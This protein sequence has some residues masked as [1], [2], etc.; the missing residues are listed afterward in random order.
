M[1]DSLYSS[2]D[3]DINMPLNKLS[4]LKISGK[5]GFKTHHIQITLSKYI[6]SDFL[7][8]YL[9]W[10]KSKLSQLGEFLE[11]FYYVI[12]RLIMDTRTFFRFLCNLKLSSKWVGHHVKR[13]LDDIIVYVFKMPKITA[14]ESK[15][16]IKKRTKSYIMG[17]SLN[18]SKKNQQQLESYQFCHQYSRNIC[19]YKSSCWSIPSYNKCRST[20]S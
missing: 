4:D 15:Q 18:L 8:K 14:S 20:M 3:C 6:N 5:S 16:K 12:P 13:K 17:Q 19:A 11:H 2:T 9:I 1:V 7:S 10:S